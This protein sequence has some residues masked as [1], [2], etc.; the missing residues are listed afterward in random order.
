MYREIA[1]KTLTGKGKIN[2]TIEKEIFISN[3]ISKK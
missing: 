2:Q 3:E 1:A